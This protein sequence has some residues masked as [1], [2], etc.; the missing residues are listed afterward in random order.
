MFAALPESKI[1]GYK[2]GRFSFNVR[3]GRCES[4]KG[5][6]YNQI[7]MQFLSDIIVPCEV[8]QGQRYNREAMEVKLRGHSIADV[9]GMTVETALGIFQNHHRIR[10][11][12]ETLRDVGLGYIRLG[13]PATTLSGGEAQ[14]VE[15]GDRVVQTVHRAHLY[16]LDEPTTGL[17]FDDCAALLL[18]LHRLVDQGNSVLLIEHNMELI[19]NADW[20]IDLGPGAGDSGGRLL[21][22]GTPEQLADDPGESDRPLPTSGAG[23]ERGAGRMTASV[24]VVLVGSRSHPDRSK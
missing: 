9:L 5:D 10:N 18:V 7:E 24:G 12:L 16:L 23:A 14:R 8:C 6:G 13:Q 20:L 11:R 19:K 3:G 2:P 22:F 1:R 17:S 4:C 21:A 15:T